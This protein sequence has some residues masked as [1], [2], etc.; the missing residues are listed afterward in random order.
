MK[1]AKNLFPLLFVLVL[2]L[3]LTAC[4][5]AKTSGEADFKSELE[6]GYAAAPGEHAENSAL[7]PENRGKSN[8]AVAIA[9]PAPSSDKIIYSGYAEIE[10]LDFDKTLSDLKEMVENCGGF[11]QNSS[12]AGGNY[13]AVYK[14]RNTSRTADYTIRIPVEKFDQVKE[15]LKNLGNVVSSGT[16]AENITM[17][18]TDT[19]SRLAACR[20]KEARLLDLLSK[21]E[22]MEDILAI[23]NALSDVRYEIE[24]LTSQIKNWDS[25]ITYST[26]TVSVREV[27]LYSKGN[28]SSV[29]YGRQ[30]KEAFVH[31]LYAVGQFFKDL[32]KFLAGALPVIAV[33]A[34]FAAAG[35]FIVKAVRKKK[36]SKTPAESDAT[37]NSR[38]RQ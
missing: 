8:G 12:V 33:A 5:T 30:L 4:G 18:Y 15:S 32:L 23:E 14:G 20:T 38:N 27:A 25:L 17:Q 24:S 19:E 28:S 37:E 13:E 10:T 11:F 34:L 21:A 22:S 9:V 1:T 16:N 6:S 26:L 31:S 29:S 36:S 2:S 7:S 35:F 3:A